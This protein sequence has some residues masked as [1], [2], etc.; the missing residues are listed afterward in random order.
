[1]PPSS[2]AKAVAGVERVIRVALHT[3]VNPDRRAVHG[4]MGETVL[5]HPDHVDR[6]DELNRP[7][8]FQ[9][10]VD[11]TPNIVDVRKP[12]LVEERI[13][14]GFGKDPVTVDAQAQIL[15]AEEAQREAAEKAVAA[16]AEAEAAAKAGSGS[17]AG[18]G[19]GS[20]ADSGSGAKA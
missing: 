13:M 17:G 4:R 8:S 18:A 7:P 1:M 10:I 20:G 14:Q 16:Q 15:A 2:S 5:V 11:N 19:S 3:Y 12:T 9:D 6:F